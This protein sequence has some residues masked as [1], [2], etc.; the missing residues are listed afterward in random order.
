MINIHTL[1]LG[2]FLIE[3][4]LEESII[5]T[6]APVLKKSDPG[7]GRPRI[8]V[9]AKACTPLFNSVKN[10]LQQNFAMDINSCKCH[11]PIWICAMDILSRRS[12]SHG[13]IH[14]DTECTSVGN[15]SVIIFLQA[16]KSSGIKLW[17]NSQQLF[18]GNQFEVNN[19]PKDL[20]RHLESCDSIMVNPVKKRAIIFDSRL[21]HQSMAHKEMY[22]RYAYSFGIAC[23]GL[24]VIM[25]DSDVLIVETFKYI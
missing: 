13:K 24:Y 21:V 1:S 18:E 5:P 2:G 7:V 22:H 14:R 12:Q 25:D 16:S 9:K 10:I 8:L 6:F 4:D 23:N 20:A 11:S 15:L 19:R 3:V 17:K